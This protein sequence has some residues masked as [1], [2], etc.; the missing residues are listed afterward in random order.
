MPK[1][2]ALALIPASARPVSPT[3]IKVHKDVPLAIRES[4]A[5]FENAI[6]GRQALIECLSTGDSDE[7]VSE[8]LQLLGD[9]R[10]DKEP[11]AKI[12]AQ[13][14][15]TPGQLFTAFDRAAVV[16]AHVLARM[17]AANKIPEIT[18]EVTRTALPH[19]KVCTTCN[20][21]GSFE[22]MKSVNGKDEYVTEVCVACNGVGSIKREGDPDQQQRAFELTG[23]LK[24]G[25]GTQVTQSLTMVA[26][27]VNV[28]S[29]SLEQL[30]QAVSDLIYRRPT[31]TVESVP[32][33]ASETPQ[34]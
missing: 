15:I 16:R 19:D 32:I 4:I 29:G 5:A 20:G 27:S 18:R 25:G 1:K 31:L 6:G 28:Q 23:L 3:Q 21:V 12:C 30:Q 7:Q 24:S 13:T 8:V 22:R 14:G 11:L 9:P 33:A 10:N 34:P 26:P 2:R 17:E